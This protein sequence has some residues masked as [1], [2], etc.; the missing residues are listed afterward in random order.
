VSEMIQVF[1]VMVSV[2]SIIILLEI[3][4]ILIFLI[5]ELKEL[6]VRRSP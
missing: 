5:Q 6:P 1:W 4:L 3:Y 2:L